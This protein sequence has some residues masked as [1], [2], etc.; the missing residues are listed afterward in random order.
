ME[1]YELNKTGQLLIWSLSIPVNE[2]V[3]VPGQ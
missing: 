3:G 2:G 1:I